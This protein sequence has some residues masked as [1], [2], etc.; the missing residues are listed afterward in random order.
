M[1]GVCPL[2]AQVRT[3]VGRSLMP[4]SSTNTISLPSRM[5]F[6]EGWPF[7]AFP[8]PYN[9]LIA[10][11]GPLIRLLGAKAQRA[12][13]TPDLGLAELDAV[14]AMDD[15]TDALEGPQ[16]CAKAMFRWIL[17]NSTVQLFPLGLIELGRSA[18]QWHATQGV[19]SAFFEKRL[20]CV[21]GLQR[22]LRST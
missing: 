4:D 17:Q 2:G 14:H 6:F 1:M 10:L 12:Q 9:I 18:S 3:R 19:N 20:P 21:Y 7:A 8:A 16:F 22:K 13:H 5:A 11:D 15:H